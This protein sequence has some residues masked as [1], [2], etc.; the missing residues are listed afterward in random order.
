MQNASIA[1]DICSRCHQYLPLVYLH[2]L[3]RHGYPVVFV[4][5]ACVLWLLLIAMQY[6]ARRLYKI[7]NLLIHLHIILAYLP[8]N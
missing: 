7:W 6:N 3:V 5:Q 1:I 2:H 8:T 4:T